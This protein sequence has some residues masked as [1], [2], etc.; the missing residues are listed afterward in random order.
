[1]AFSQSPHI[2]AEVATSKLVYCSHIPANH[3][4]QGVLL[5]STQRC[6]TTHM[7][8]YHNAHLSGTYLTF[9]LLAAL[10]SAAPQPC[11]AWLSMSARAQK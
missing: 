2:T 11:D 1:M 6:C 3:T 7:H 4:R 8:C 5:V 10:P 9:V